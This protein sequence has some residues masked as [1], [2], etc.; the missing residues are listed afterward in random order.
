MQQVGSIREG[1]QVSAQREEG[2]DGMIWA[3]KDHEDTIR[4]LVEDADPTGP[5][6]GGSGA[7]RRQVPWGGTQAANDPP[8]S[9]SG[10]T[11]DA[12]DG[13]SHEHDHTPT[14]S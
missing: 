9:G 10:S 8:A 7:A 5:L 14:I 3:P 4:M 1:S 6:T 2:D 12:D 11:H 13:H